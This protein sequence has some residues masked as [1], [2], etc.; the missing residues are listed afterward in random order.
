M[1]VGFNGAGDEAI[2]KAT[3]VAEVNARR[4]EALKELEKAKRDT[5]DTPGVSVGLDAA[6]PAIN[7]QSD[8]RIKM[9]ED[10]SKAG[11]APPPPGATSRRGTT[12]TRTSP[13]TAS[14]GIR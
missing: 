4:G 8:R 7:T 1:K 10:A 6:M 11:R 9:L 2:A 5:K 13:S 14:P 12:A 3:T